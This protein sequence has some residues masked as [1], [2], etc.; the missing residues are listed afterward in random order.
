MKLFYRALVILLPLL[1]ASFAAAQVQP[2]MFSNII[3]IVQENRTPDNIFGAY[4]TTPC[5]NNGNGGGY[6]LP[7]ADLVNGTTNMGNGTG[8]VCNAPYPMDSGV[9]PTPGHQQSDWLFDYN[10]GSMNQFCDNTYTTPC[11][12]YSFVVNSAGTTDVLP[13]YQIA[14]TYGFAN[15]MFQTNEG[16]SYPAHQF[17]F[18]GTSAPVAPNDPNYYQYFVVNNP[19][20]TLNGTGGLSGCP[21]QVD[22]S[23]IDPLRNVAPGQDGNLE[24]YPHDSLVT[25]STCQSNATLCDKSSTLFTSSWRYYAPEPGSIWDAP[26]AIPEVCYGVNSTSN[27][28]AACG[29]V[30]VNNQNYNHQNWTNHMSF[31][32]VEAGA[33]IL[34]D[35]ANCHLQQISWV[36]PDANWSDHP[37]SSTIPALGPYWV[38]NIVD[39]IGNSFANSEGACDYWGNVAPSGSSARKPTAIF[40]V[41]DDWGG[42]YDHVP[43]QNAYI[44]GGSEGDSTCTKAP[45]AWGCGYVYGFR[46]PFLVVSE[47]TGGNLQNGSYI[48][49][50]CGPGFSASCPNMAPPYVHDFGSILKFTEYNFGLQNIDQSGHNGYAD[51]N[52]LDNVGTNISLQDFFQLYPGSPRSFVQ[53]PVTN[54]PA[55]FFQNYYTTHNATPTGPDPD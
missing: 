32:S 12:P 2:G 45:N 3:I 47:Y 28:P 44:G 55:S 20:S 22:L 17:L 51:N 10:G 41:W 37:N 4:A 52:A 42:F 49:G 8:L 21:Q 36:I 31:Y 50:A 54:Y 27:V 5:S 29:S 43:P 24:C 38:A 6:T 23:W 19:T 40:I 48:S 1:L 14:A 7:G 15:Y 53:I 46:V 34:S 33:P 30:L 11:F 35:I 13:Y 39:A 18:T 16:P 9:Y 26:E 25:G